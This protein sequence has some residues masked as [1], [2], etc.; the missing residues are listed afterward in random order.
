MQYPMRMSRRRT[1][2]GSK[3]TCF[4]LRQIDH[5][6][7]YIIVVCTGPRPIQGLTQSSSHVG[8]QEE[9]ANDSRFGIVVGRKEVGDMSAS[10]E[11]V[12]VAFSEGG[13]GVSE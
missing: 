7:R 10:E 3:E 13:R 9:L 4:K 8:L 2:T 5:I 6:P 12:G 11:I 1:G